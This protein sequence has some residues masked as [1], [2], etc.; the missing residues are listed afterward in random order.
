MA[1]Q[2]LPLYKGLH[3]RMSNITHLGTSTCPTHLSSH[4][5]PHTRV[6]HTCPTHAT[7]H[8]Y[9]TPG[10]LLTHLS[11]TPGPHT[12]PHTPVLT[13]VSLIPA[14]HT[15]PHTSTTHLYHVPVLIHLSSHTCPAHLYHTPVL[16]HTSSHA[17]PHTPVPHTCPHT[18]MLTHRAFITHGFSLPQVLLA[19]LLGRAVGAR[20]VLPAGRVRRCYMSLTLSASVCACDCRVG[21]PLVRKY[22]AQ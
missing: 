11:H 17:C 3:T 18:R 10:P 20:R 12:C 16:T 13:H 8:L 4:T 6:P 15:Q 7:T 5:C 9:H 14:P 22:T 21:R 2:I 19:G 1:H